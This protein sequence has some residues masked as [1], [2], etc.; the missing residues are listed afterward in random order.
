MRNGDAEQGPGG[1]DEPVTSVT[2]W[3]IVEGTPTLIGYD[4]A[5]GLLT[6]QDPGP[7]RRGSRYFAGGTAART[8]LLQDVALP[9]D[10]VTGRAAVDAGTVRFRAAAWLGGPGDQQDGARL[11]VEFRDAA[12]VP[13]A[14]AVLGPV[15]AE[16]RNHL[17]GTYERTAEAAV[18]P[19]ARTARV[20]L[21]L[22]RDGGDTHG[23]YADALSLVLHV[24]AKGTV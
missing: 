14:L 5:K 21:A 9:A 22:T 4:F 12:G 19:G 8:T 10:G 2:G 18:P 13:V 1:S 24:D 3:E 15:T 23:G 7:P 16:E 17:T 11:S 20:L 6:R